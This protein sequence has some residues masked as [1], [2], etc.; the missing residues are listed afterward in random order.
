MDD[1]VRT[2]KRSSDAEAAG[3]SSEETTVDSDTNADMRDVAGCDEDWVI[4]HIDAIW[5]GRTSHSWVCA[6]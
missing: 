4:Y 2:L 5:G 3:H 1:E 6:D